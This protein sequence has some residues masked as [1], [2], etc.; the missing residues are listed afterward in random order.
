M[1]TI[2]GWKMGLPTLPW[3]IPLGHIPR[4]HSRMLHF[5]HPFRAV[6]TDKPI[7]VERMSVSNNRLLRWIYDLLNLLQRNVGDDSKR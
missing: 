1:R 7:V 6:G 2:F 4:Q 3:A 5:R